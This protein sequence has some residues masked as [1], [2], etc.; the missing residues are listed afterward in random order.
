M[1][2][3]DRFPCYFSQG[4]GR[5][6]LPLFSGALPPS[7][8]PLDSCSENLFIII[9]HSDLIGT[10]FYSIVKATVHR[11]LDARKQQGQFLK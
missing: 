11:L 3:L 8:L 4:V 5:W 7:H 6:T 9:K 10:C 1:C 2:S